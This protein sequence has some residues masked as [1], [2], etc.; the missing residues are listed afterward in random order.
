MNDYLK[1]RR[2][3]LGLTQEDL[4]KLLNINISLSQ[5]RNIESGRT[6]NPKLETIK[7]ILKALQLPLTDIEKLF[8]DENSCTILKFDK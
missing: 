4:L 2:I 7:E 3:Q 6:N 1:N 8:P 5:Y